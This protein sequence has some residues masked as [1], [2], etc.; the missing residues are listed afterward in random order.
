M[1]KSS[2]LLMELINAVKS[3]D[4]DVYLDGKKITKT[5]NDNNNADI[6]AGKRPILI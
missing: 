2:R 1:I 3:I 6:R 5:V 4:T